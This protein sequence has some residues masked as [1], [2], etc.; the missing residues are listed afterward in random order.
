MLE[1][2]LVARFNT[3]WVLDSET[4]C[5][6]WTASVAG[7]MGYG[8]IKLPRER[9]QAYA[10]R[11]SYMIHHGEIP[12]GRQICHRC[13]T[14]RCVNPE[15]LFLGTSQDNHDDMVAKGRGRGGS[16]VGE[17]NPSAKLSETEVREIKKLLAAGVSGRRIAKFFSISSPLVSMIAKGKLWSHVLIS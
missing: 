16:S 1:E 6:L 15:H 2:S 9:K 8:Q 13:D 7:P 4:G 14:P 5:W 3:K 12:V 10:H 17:T 11:V